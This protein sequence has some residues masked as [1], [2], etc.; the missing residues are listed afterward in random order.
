MAPLNPDSVLFSGSEFIIKKFG[1]SFEEQKENFIAFSYKEIS[2]IIM[3]KADNGTVI[4][5]DILFSSFNNPHI[6]KTCNLNYR[7]HRLKSCLLWMTR[8]NA[9]YPS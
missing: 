7:I 3:E 6:T 9:L 5:N 4:K 8:L 1:S 2:K